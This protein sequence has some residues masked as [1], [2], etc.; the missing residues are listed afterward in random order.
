M[1]VHGFHGVVALLV[2]LVDISFRQSDP[3]STMAVD[4]C[5]VFLVP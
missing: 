4:T 2:V 5:D 3:F 1:V